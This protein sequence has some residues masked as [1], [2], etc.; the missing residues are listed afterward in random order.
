MK[1][2]HLDSAITGDNSISRK[3]SASIVAHLTAANPG[4][5]ITYRDLV[6]APIDHLTLSVMPTPGASTANGTISPA[7]ALATSRSRRPYSVLT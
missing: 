4:L 6:A 7:P 3:L 1:L 5:T 2:L